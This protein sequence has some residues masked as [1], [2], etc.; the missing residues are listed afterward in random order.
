M[1]TRSVDPADIARSFD[2]RTR[3]FG[4]APP[5]SRPEWEARARAAIDEVF[6]ND[7]QIG[8]LSGNWRLGIAIMIPLGMVGRASHSYLEQ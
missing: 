1:E 3:A 6:E 4:V 7:K 2:I 8:R 5:S